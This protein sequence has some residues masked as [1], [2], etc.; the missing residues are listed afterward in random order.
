MGRRDMYGFLIA[1]IP[2]SCRQSWTTSYRARVEG[3]AHQNSSRS[4]GE[5]L[6]RVL[7]IG[8]SR[9]FIDQLADSVAGTSC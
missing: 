7:L 4:P 1:C 2:I 5:Q 6:D 8:N 3:G 9:L